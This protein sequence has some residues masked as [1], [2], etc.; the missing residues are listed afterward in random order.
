MSTEQLRDQGYA[1]GDVMGE[2][3]RL[4][5]SGK[6]SAPEMLAIRKAINDSYLRTRTA[7]EVFIE[8][9]EKTKK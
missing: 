9:R 6:F 4:A 1:L 5:A 2:A 3:D 7:N 8:C